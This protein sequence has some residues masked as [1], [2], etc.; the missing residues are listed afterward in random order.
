VEIDASGFL[1]PPERTLEVTFHVLVPA[2]A[3][4]WGK[5][6][7]MCMQFDHPKLG[8]WHHNAGEFKMIRLI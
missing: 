8:S 6:S 4:N 7:Y 3:W 1:P 5:N 2:D